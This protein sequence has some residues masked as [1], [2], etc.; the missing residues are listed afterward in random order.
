MV[1]LETVHYL[2]EKALRIREY[3]VNDLTGVGKVGHLGGSCSSADVEGIRAGKVTKLANQIIAALN[4]AAISEALVLAT[5][6]DVDPELVFQAIRC[7]LARSTVLN[8]KAPLVLNRK[9]MSGFLLK[10]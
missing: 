9:F 4:I 10:I 8:A 7:G 6:A 1:S 2:E 3:L 5:K